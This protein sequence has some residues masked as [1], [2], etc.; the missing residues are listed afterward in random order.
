MAKSP[1]KETV[2]KDVEGV[3]DLDGETTLIEVEGYEEPLSF[4]DI[5]SMFNG[6]RVKISMTLS[7]ETR[8]EEE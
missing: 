8:P 3:L 1:I 5:Y 6:R 4:N 2:K 7:V